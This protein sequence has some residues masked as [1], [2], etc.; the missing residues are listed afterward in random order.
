MSPS[1][2]RIAGDEPD[3]FQDSAPLKQV[4]VE[5]AATLVCCVAE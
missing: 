2:R 3:I 5:I 1:S 4:E